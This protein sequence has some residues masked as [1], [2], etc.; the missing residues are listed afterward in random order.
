M[1]CWVSCVSCGGLGGV[2]SPTSVRVL[3]K[4][5]RALVGFIIYNYYSF[6]CISLS[7]LTFQK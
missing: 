4:K 7:V 3:C 1:L 5:L 2:G 6:F